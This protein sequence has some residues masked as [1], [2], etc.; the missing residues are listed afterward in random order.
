MTFRTITKAAELDQ[1]VKSS[2]TEPVVIY[3]HS[4]SCELCWW[5]EAGLKESEGPTIHKIVVQDARPLSNLVESRF[6]IRHESP[7]VIVIVDGEPVF[8]ASHRGV[9][10]R[11]VRKATGV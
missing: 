10:P 11:A 8:D 7:Q 6:S 4:R 2:Y 9:T 1:A 3:K 5:A